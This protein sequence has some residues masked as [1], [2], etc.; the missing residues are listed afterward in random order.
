MK[1]RSLSPRGSASWEVA[2]ALQEEAD[3]PPRVGRRLFL[4]SILSATVPVAFAIS[5]ASGAIAAPRRVLRRPVTNARVSK[6]GAF[7]INR[8]GTG[9]HRGVDFAVDGEAVYAA[10]GGVITKASYGAVGGYMITIEHRAFGL[11]TH[12]AHLRKGSIL[13]GVGAKVKQGERIGTSGNSG[14]GSNGPHLH[15]EVHDMSASAM[16]EKTARNPMNYFK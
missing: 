13:R 1:F 16:S 12:Y 2:P 4:R 6:G 8:P 9:K 10:A 14:S 15:F 5:G 7:G 3:R 11:R